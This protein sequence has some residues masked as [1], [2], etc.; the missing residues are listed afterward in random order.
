MFGERGYHKV[1]TWVYAFNDRSRKLHEKFG[2]TLEGTAREAHFAAGEF[3][4]ECL[5]GMTA[6]EFWAR[7]GR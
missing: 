3:H 5:Y 7:Y 4:D 6:A 2:M 1:Y